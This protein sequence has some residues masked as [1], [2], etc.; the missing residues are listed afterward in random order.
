MPGLT[1]I[2][3]TEVT[4]PLAKY[5][6]LPEETHPLLA[7]IPP[8]QRG[9]SLNAWKCKQVSDQAHEWRKAEREA[10]AKT[11]VARKPEPVAESGDQKLWDGK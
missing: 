2:S 11:K 1:K 4:T 5:D 10:K 3:N 6:V 9:M 7:R 8:D